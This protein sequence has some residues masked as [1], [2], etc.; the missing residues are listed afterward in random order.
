MRKFSRLINLWTSFK[1]VTRATRMMRG[2][3]SV[4]GRAEFRSTVL[5]LGWVKP[6]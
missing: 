5:A 2:F 1:S 6:A 3:E 4:S